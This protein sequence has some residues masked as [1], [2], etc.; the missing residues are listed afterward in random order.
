MT[1][2]CGSSHLGRVTHL[3]PIFLMGKGE[4]DPVSVSYKIYVKLCKNT[5]E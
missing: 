3:V 2:K 4:R 1:Q 5:K